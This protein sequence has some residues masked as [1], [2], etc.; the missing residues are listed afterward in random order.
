[1][2]REQFRQLAESWGGDIG[3]WPPDLRDAARRLAEHDEQ[4]AAML[5]AQVAFDR[6]L[7]IPPEVDAARAGRA[8]LSVLQRIAAAETKAETKAT[9]APWYQRLLWPESLVPAGSLACS[10][11]LGVWMASTLPYHPDAQALEA[12]SAVFD[13]SAFTL[14]GAQ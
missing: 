1:M 2:N 8:G 12:V 13:A 9:R 4:A 10:A 6:L 11:L 5:R 7:A 14:W 3:R